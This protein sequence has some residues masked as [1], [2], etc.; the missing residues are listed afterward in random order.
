MNALKCQA[1]SCAMLQGEQEVHLWNTCFRLEATLFTKTK[2][3]ERWH[4]LER[5]PCIFVS[6]SRY[7]G[8]TRWI[9]ASRM[10]CSQVDSISGYLNCSQSPRSVTFQLSVWVHYVRKSN[11]R[12]AY[13]YFVLD[14]G[15]IFCFWDIVPMSDADW[16][17]RPRLICSSTA[18]KRC[19]FTGT[20]GWK[21]VTLCAVNQGGY[22]LPKNTVP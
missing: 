12:F 20:K 15:Q 13:S 10:N 21:Q 2:L 14:S 16:E 11:E 3:W 6:L 19:S 18:L 5:L 9:P 17:T 7:T 4:P 22:R 8:S 1:W